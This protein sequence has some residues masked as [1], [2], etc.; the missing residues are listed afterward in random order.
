MAHTVTTAILHYVQYENLDCLFRTGGNKCLIF[1]LL[2]KAYRNRVNR[3][4]KRV[5]A[6]RG[7]GTPYIRGGSARQG[8]LF[9]SSGI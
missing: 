3:L 6:A 9:Q 2:K 4:E 5:L 8:N 1:F 7:G